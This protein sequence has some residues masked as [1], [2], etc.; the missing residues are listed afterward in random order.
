MSMHN[1]ALVA[2]LVVSVTCGVC[3]AIVTTIDRGTWPESWPK[4]LEGCRRQAKT[5]QVAHGIQ[6]TVYE[7]PFDSREEFEKAWPHVLKLKS[8]GA[9]LILEKSPSTYHVSGSTMPAGVRILWPSGA[10]VELPDGT[11]LEAKPPWPESI[12]SASGEL[13]EYVVAEA[14]KWVS[15]TRGQHKGFLNRAR[16]DIV[17]V[18]DGRVVDLNRIELPGETP[19]L[20][21]RFKKSSPP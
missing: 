3:H 8:R 6:E 1:R 11:R 16:V 2:L 21:R 18:V 14:G 5:V 19:I 15:F 10:T 17:L 9:P 4:E 13:P 20:D 7:I 12:Q